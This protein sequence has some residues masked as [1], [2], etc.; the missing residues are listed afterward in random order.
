VFPRFEAGC[1]LFWDPC[2]SAFRGPRTSGSYWGLSASS[3]FEARVASVVC[4]RPTCLRLSRPLLP[5][6][7]VFLLATQRAYEI[8]LKYTYVGLYLYNINSH[9]S[10][11]VEHCYCYSYSLLYNCC[12]NNATHCYLVF[13]AYLS[14]L[15]QQQQILPTHNLAYSCYI[16]TC[17]LYNLTSTYTSWTLDRS[18]G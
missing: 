5:P 17:C 2:V 18:F 4:S 6:F 8:R 11:T 16:L 15:W 3:V 9:S 1:L 13:T 12:D 7:R 14:L 10:K